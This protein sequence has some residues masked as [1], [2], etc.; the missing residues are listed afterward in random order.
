M[1][2]LVIAA[3][4]LGGPV[5]VSLAAASGPAGIGSQPATQ[6]VPGV[7]LDLS[8]QLAGPPGETARHQTHLQSLRGL[9]GAADTP[10]DQ[11]AAHLAI[12]NWLLSVPTARPATRWLIGVEQAADL[13]AMAASA[14]AAQRHLARAR[15]LLRADES[16]GD[17]EKK[18]QIQLQQA[19][20]V[21]D[22]LAA[23]FAAADPQVDPEQ[24]RK[25]YGNAALSLAVLRESDDSNVA[26]CAL[27]WQ[28]FGWE[29]AGRRK[30]ALLSLPEVLA[31]PEHS[32]YDF[33]CRLLRCRIITDAGQHAAA[34]TL[35]IHMQI[36]C[37]QWF[38]EAPPGEVE[39][40]RLLI[41][42]L[43]CRAGQAWLSQL[44]ASDSP[45]AA[46]RL[47]AMLAT[48]QE[49]LVSGGKRQNVYHLEQAVPII[50]E[51]PVVRRSVPSTVPAPAT[52][53][54]SVPASTDGTQRARHSSTQS[55]PSF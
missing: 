17:A 40:R 30:R 43:Q 42:L 35:A 10:L 5:E 19:A 50:A 11:A 23:L 38:P 13:R 52:A 46:A 12:A 36:L 26:A 47:E 24:R 31:Q 32:P 44:K 8:G 45:A 7:M 16:A 29:L 1:K 6:P 9:L 51:P 18:R 22:P 54:G 25:A 4:L 55:L 48:V 49:A 20:A 27:L 2:P 14:G 3:L 15:S 53:P 34:T 21:L 41:A 33:L 28:S 37:P 39:A